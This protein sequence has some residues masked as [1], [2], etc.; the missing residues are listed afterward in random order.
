MYLVSTYYE[1]ECHLCSRDQAA[2]ESMLYAFG[3]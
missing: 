1:Q 3:L 2:D